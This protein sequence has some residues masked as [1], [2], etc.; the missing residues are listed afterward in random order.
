MNKEI[1]VKLQNKLIEEKKRL[2][3]ELKNFAVKDP[4][5]KDDWTTKFPKYG[6]EINIDEAESQK[7]VEDY[8]N[9]LPVEYRLEL[10]LRDINEA[11]ERMG[12]NMYGFCQTSDVGQHEIEIARLEVNP[13]AKLCLKHYKKL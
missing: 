1:L 9:A 4:K 8:L 7:E 10:R 2:E 12:K 6:E 5:V 11:I 3:S 13:E